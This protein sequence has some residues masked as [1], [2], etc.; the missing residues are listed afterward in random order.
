MNTPFST[1]STRLVL[2]QVR[3]DPPVLLGR[4]EDLVVDPAAVRRLQQRV[5]E[6]EDEAAAGPSTRAT[7]AIAVVERRRCARTRGRRPPRRT[8]ASANGQRGRAGPGV[9]RSPAA[10]G[11]RPRPAPRS[12]RRRRPR[13][14]RRPAASR[15]TCPRRMP[16]SSTRPRPGQGVG[17]QREDL[18]LVL[19]VGAVGEPVL[20]PAG[21]G[22]PE[23]VAHRRALTERLH[24]R[25][26]SWMLLVDRRR[27]P[28]RAATTAPAAPRA[29]ASFTAFT[30]PSSF[31]SRLR[32]VGPGRGC[33][34]A[35]SSSS[36]ACPAAR[37]GR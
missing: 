35:P 23:L 26:R 34:R 30:P 5:V 12:G 18:L 9:G 4:V 14:R 1:S 24:R 33:R 3:A 11:A 16:T 2:D 8:L 13:R 22:L 19:G 29:V 15:A 37:G 32:R 25:R 27:P 7:S 10:R 20:P 21:V 17:R 36:C 31:T 6:E 28:R